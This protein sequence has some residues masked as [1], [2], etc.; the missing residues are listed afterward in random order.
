VNPDPESGK[1]P[2][3]ETPAPGTLA[4]HL[5]QTAGLSP[6]LDKDRLRP[7]ESIFTFIGPTAPGEDD[8]TGE[9]EHEAD[10]LGAEGPLFAFHHAF[11]DGLL[12]EGPPGSLYFE[13]WC[14]GFEDLPGVWFTCRDF[15]PFTASMS[16]I[17]EKMAREEIDGGD[18]YAESDDAGYELIVDRR[19]A[20]SE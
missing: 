13:A 16:K 14:P 18:L 11:D 19:M 17:T 15:S 9:T 3:D 20:Q 4:E 8:G 5:S 7:A 2:S 6:M 10:D 1:R 12:R